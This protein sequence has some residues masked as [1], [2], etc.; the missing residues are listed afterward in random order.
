MMRGRSH[1]TTEPKTQRESLNTSVTAS[2][3][4][5]YLTTKEGN[6][7]SPDVEKK[8]S[9]PTKNAKKEMA[10]LKGA[11]GDKTREETQTEREMETYEGDGEEQRSIAQMPTKIEMMAMFE[12]MESLI[13]SEITNVRM[14]LGHLLRRV[15]EAE[16]RTEKQTQEIAELKS[17]VKA[18][19]IN[20]RN[21][22]YKMEAQ[23]NQN[24]RQNLRIRALPEQNGEK[25]E[26]KIRKIFNPLLGREEDEELKIDRV[27]RIRKPLGMKEETPRDVIVKFHRYTDKEKIWRNLRERHPL[28]YEQT[29][30]QVFADLSSETLS[31]RRQLKPL[32]EHLRQANIKYSWGFPAALIVHRDG[33]TVRLKFPEE[34]QDFCTELQIPTISIPKRSEREERLIEE[35]IGQRA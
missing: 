22:F 11:Q 12:R 2:S 27:H 23:E 28:Q 31:R 13:K 33:K 21:T 1:K 32:L 17:Q 29:T 20:Q 9:L 19:Q 6:Q 26:E 7:K 3:I 18:L 10:K 15:E 8:T 34:V 24:R 16:E 14:D 30:L 25:L 5:K 4:Q 35:G